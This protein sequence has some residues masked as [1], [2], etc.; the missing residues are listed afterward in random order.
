MRE[1]FIGVMPF[2]VAEM[3]RVALLLAFPIITLWLPRVLN[4]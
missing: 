2:F 1:T 3:F 4:G